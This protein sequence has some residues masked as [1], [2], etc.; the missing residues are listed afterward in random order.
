MKRALQVLI[1]LGVLAAVGLL[2]PFI[3]VIPIGLGDWQSVRSDTKK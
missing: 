2:V 3:L 1:S